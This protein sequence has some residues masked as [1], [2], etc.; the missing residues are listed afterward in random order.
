MVRPAG[1]I[2]GGPGQKRT[3]GKGRKRPAARGGPGRRRF[4]WVGGGPAPRAIFPLPRSPSEQ[5]S[6]DPSHCR[7]SHCPTLTYWSTLRLWSRRTRR[8]IAPCAA[9]CISVTCQVGGFFSLQFMYSSSDKGRG[10]S[11]MQPD[12]AAEPSN[13]KKEKGEEANQTS[14]PRPAGPRGPRE[15]RGPRRRRRR[16][17]RLRGAAR[18]GGGSH[19]RLGRGG[20]EKL[21]L[22]PPP[23]DKKKRGPAAKSRRPLSCHP[24][25]PIREKAVG[26][27]WR[28]LASCRNALPVVERIDRIC[29]RGRRF[30]APG[31]GP[32]PNRPRS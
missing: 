26:I 21:V 29:K 24:S 16:P 2:K 10:A 9:I 3:D 5:E 7:A 19:R 20:G 22:S 31:P 15:Q 27:D 18:P 23:A 12:E 1:G 8:G 28:A 25:I 17:R 30:R 11:S 32:G 14:S 13:K 6:R 4:F